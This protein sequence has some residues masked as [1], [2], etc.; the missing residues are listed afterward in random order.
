MSG[1]AY[2]YRVAVGTVDRSGARTPP[3]PDPTASI[4]HD[5]EAP[6]GQRRDLAIWLGLALTGLAITFLAVRIGAHLGTRSAPFLGSYRFNLGFASLLAPALA[7]LVLAVAA[8][9]RFDAL[10]MRHLLAASWA[11]SF[12]WAVALTFV[13]GAAGLT[14]SL[15]NPDNYLTD[16]PMVGDDPLAFLGNFTANAEQHSVAARGHP[17]GPVLLLWALHRLGLTDRLALGLLIT[18]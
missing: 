3:E 9:D 5:V 10:P 18:A 2:R 8:R 4:P 15:Q 13:D 7:A 17:P 12:A 11:G 6:G 14:R 1:S 16:V